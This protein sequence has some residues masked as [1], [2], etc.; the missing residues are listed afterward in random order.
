MNNH[1]LSLPIR[2][3]ND[4]NLTRV[5][6][7]MTARCKCVPQLIMILASS[8]SLRNKPHNIYVMTIQKPN[9]M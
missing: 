6:A 1:Y 9:S 5:P 8:C 7:R 3:V 4:N 2:E